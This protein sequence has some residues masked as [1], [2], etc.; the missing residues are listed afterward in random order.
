MW[1]ETVAICTISAIPPV[2]RP[3]ECQAYSWLVLFITTSRPDD[4]PDITIYLQ[5]KWSHKLFLDI[6]S[7]ITCKDEVIGLG[8]NLDVDHNDIERIIEG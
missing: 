2:R 3:T 7:M 6:A 5:V 4:I 8:L 1:F